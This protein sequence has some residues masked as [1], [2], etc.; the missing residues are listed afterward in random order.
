MNENDFK[1]MAEEA[2]NIAIKHI[3]D[4]IGEKTGDFASTYDFS[5]VEK[6]LANY[7]E[8]NYYW[9]NYK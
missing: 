7:A 4:K 2:L 5:D 6:T 9:L 3:Q 8:N 1:T